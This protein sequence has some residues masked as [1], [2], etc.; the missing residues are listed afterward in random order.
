MSFARAGAI[1]AF[2]AVLLG[3][4]GAHL[5]RDRLGAALSPAWETGVRYHLVHAL[6]LIAVELVRLHAGRAS[7]ALG[8]AGILFVAG[9]ALFSGSL[10]L[11]ALTG[12]RTWGAV[13]P[14]GGLCFLIGWI[15]FAIG[16]RPPRDSGAT[17]S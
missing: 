7:R 13:T 6:A 1:S 14:F 10:Y 15:A 4:F 12:V 9:T 2:L 8:L 5:L 16:A 17:R 3:A 11:L